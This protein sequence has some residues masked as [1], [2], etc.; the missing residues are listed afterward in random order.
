MKR[1][2]DTIILLGKTGKSFRGHTEKNTDFNK[3][4][5]LEIFLIAYFNS[6]L[7][8]NNHYLN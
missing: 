5:F 6:A 3:G 7:S 2:I 4:M 1:L 8:T